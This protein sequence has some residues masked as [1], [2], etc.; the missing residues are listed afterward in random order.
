MSEEWI[1]LTNRQPTINTRVEA[2]VESV[3]GYR[4]VEFLYLRTLCG[5]LFWD[6]NP[7]SSND[8]F[9]VYSFEDVSYWR[10]QPYLPQ[11]PLKKLTP[12]GVA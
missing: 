12:A 6:E 7:P 4:H 3:P 5:E 10:P 2:I 9:S 1:L 8:F 11:R